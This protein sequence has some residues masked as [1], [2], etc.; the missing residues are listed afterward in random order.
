[1][2]GARAGILLIEGWIGG[3]RASVCVSAGGVF[4]GGG[5]SRR[6][7][8]IQAAHGVGGGARAGLSRSRRCM[9]MRHLGQ[10]KVLDWSGGH[11]SGG[12]SGRCRCSRKEAMAWWTV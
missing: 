4:G 2:N 6:D 12:D 11:S 9:G 1:M 7:L 8:M 3:L 10:R 5:E